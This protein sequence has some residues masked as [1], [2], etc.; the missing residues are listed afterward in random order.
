MRLAL[1]SSLT[2]LSLS[3][4]LA[5][6]PPSAHMGGT[7]SDG[8][9]GDGGL[10]GIPVGS[11][12][13]E[14]AR[15]ACAGYETCCPSPTIDTPMCESL[16][17]DTCNRGLGPILL[18]AK[19]GYSE[20]VAAQVAAEG[21]ALIASC[22]IG[23]VAWYNSR[24]G[25]QRVFQGTIAGGDVC[26]TRA[27]DAAAYFSCMNLVQGCIG[28]AGNFHCTAR[29]A[30][31]MTCHADPDCVEGD[32][33]QGSA[34]GSNPIFGLPGHCAPREANGAPCTA[35]GAC[36]TYLCDTMGTHQCVAL[37]QPRAYCGLH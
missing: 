24:A 20:T 23:I 4:C 14:I 22:D 5:V 10:A 6:N 21:Q 19:A 11:F 13:P 31:G 2:A 36:M 28:S 26:A 37:D 16:F 33:C 15:I 9:V 12:C 7:G 27:D 3:G 32:Y 17:T 29:L 34:P 1:C 18:D 8:G 25:L 30:T 35:N